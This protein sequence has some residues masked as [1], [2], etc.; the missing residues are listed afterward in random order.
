MQDNPTFALEVLAGVAHVNVHHAVI[1]LD[2]ISLLI[3][4]IITL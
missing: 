2:P 1:N 4:D 3:K